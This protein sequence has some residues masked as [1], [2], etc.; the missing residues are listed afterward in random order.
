[1]TKGLLRRLLGLC[2]FDDLEDIGG[3][4]EIKEFTRTVMIKRPFQFCIAVFQ[5]AKL[6][7]LELYYDFLEKYVCRQDFELCY[8]VTDSFYSAVSGDSLDKIVRPEARIWGWKEELARNRR[9]LREKKQACSSLNLLIEVCDLPPSVIL[10]KMKS[11]KINIVV[12]VFQ[13]NIMI[14]ILSAIKVS[15]M[16]FKRQ[17]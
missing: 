14:C 5:L 11:K 12:K 17:E 10:F 8:M 4:Y 7:R 2:F 15:W 6:W 3:V 9:I 1:M 16:F 13:R